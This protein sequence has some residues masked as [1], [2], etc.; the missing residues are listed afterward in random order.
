MRLLRLIV[1]VYGKRVDRVS[2]AQERLEAVRLVAQSAR[3]AGPPCADCH[4]R[5]LLGNCGNPAY[6]EPSFDPVTGE[7]AERFATPVATARA[8]DGLCGPEAL[9][10]EPQMPVILAARIVWGGI[11]AIWLTLS[12]ALL[13]AA[14]VVMILGY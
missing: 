2:A 14:I 8:I 7:Y 3:E 4:F 9:L 5:T 10:F 6:S 11:R 1:S 12:G 13:L